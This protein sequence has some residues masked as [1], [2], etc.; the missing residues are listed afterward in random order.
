ML[1]K[2]KPKGTQNNPLPA[3]KTKTPVCQHAAELDLFLG[4]STQLS[5]PLFSS[6]QF[7]SSSPINSGFRAETD[8]NRK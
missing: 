8:E 6:I 7:L 1:S 4:W 2:L 3:S 5:L